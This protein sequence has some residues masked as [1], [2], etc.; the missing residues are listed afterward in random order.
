MTLTLEL[1][2]DLAAR[3]ASLSEAERSRY[4]VA[5]LREKIT[6]EDHDRAAPLTPEDLEAIRQGLADSDAG[7]VID[8]DTARRHLFSRTGQFSRGRE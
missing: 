7:R 5:A 1:P 4:A 8:G 6:V 2:D 3:L